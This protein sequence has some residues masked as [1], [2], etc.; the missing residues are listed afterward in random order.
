MSCTKRIIF[1]FIL[2]LALSSCAVT[3]NPSAIDPKS[4]LVELAS[5][6]GFEK[7]FRH[8]MSEIAAMERFSYKEFG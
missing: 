6:E 8:W 1:S 5:K 7:A 4:N 3:N 2:I